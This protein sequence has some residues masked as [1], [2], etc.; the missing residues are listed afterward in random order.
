MAPKTDPEVDRMIIEKGGMRS[1]ITAVPDPSLVVG[2]STKL[3]NDGVQFIELCGG[4]DP[5][6]AGKVIKATEGKVPVG[7]VGF[8]GG[9]S[10]NAMTRIFSA[11]MSSPK[12]KNVGSS[13]DEN[14]LNRT[15]DTSKA[16]V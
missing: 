3:V 13:V 4:F 6:W 8:A 15:E 9:Q 16:Y 1:I 14:R 10:I 5:I 2:L 12:S 7:T 11:G